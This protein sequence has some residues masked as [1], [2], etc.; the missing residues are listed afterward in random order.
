M[1]LSCKQTGHKRDPEVVSS[2]E[3]GV[4]L[5]LDGTVIVRSARVSSRE[6]GVDLS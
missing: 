1:D 3:G 6:G 5:S 2:R 4:D